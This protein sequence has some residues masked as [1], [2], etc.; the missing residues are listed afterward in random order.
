[1]TYAAA[2][3]VETYNVVDEVARRALVTG[4]R[5]LG[6]RREELPGGAPLVAVLRYPFGVERTPSE[7]ARASRA[8]A[9]IS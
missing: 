3:D 1:V 2:D 7:P 6:A 8:A 4:A 9:T 5:V